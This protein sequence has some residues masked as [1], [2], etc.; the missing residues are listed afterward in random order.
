MKKC[1]EIKVLNNPFSSSFTSD[2][3]FKEYLMN[4]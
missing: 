1:H 2:K 4:L 3:D